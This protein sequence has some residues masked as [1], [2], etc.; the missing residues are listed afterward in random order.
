[1]KHSVIFIVF[2]ALL[3][4]SCNLTTLLPAATEEPTG[5][6]LSTTKLSPSPT[7]LTPPTAEPAAGLVADPY[8]QPLQGLVASPYWPA[9]GLPAGQMIKWQRYA[10]GEAQPPANELVELQ[11]FLDQWAK[12]NGWLA[13][14]RIPSHE[15]LAFRVR[16]LKRAQ[17]GRRL[18]LYGLDE[19]STQ[20]EGSERI[21]LPPPGDLA[22]PKALI[23]APRIEGLRQQISATGDMVEY[24]DNQGQPLL[25]VDAFRMWNNTFLEYVEPRYGGSN[26]VATL[27]PRFR[28]FIPGIEA[29]FFL[30]EKNL[31]LKQIIFLEKTLELYNAPALEPL[32]PHFFAEKKIYVVVPAITEVA[33]ASGLTSAGVAV[34]DR[35]DLFHYKDDLASTIAHEAAHVMQVK[36][37]ANRCAYE[38]GDGTI[39]NGFKDWTADHLVSA[40]EAGQVGAAHVSL[41]IYVKLKSGKSSIDETEDAITSKGKDYWD[42]CTPS[43]DRLAHVEIINTL[44]KP[45]KVVLRGPTPQTVTVNPGASLTIDIAPG[46]YQYEL[47]V[48]GYT[49]LTGKRSFS[50]GPD[51]WRILRS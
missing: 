3:L 30:L 49:T 21:Y 38:I 36:S 43:G 24:L 13:S 8:R 37:K 32:K 17:S 26:M 34:L 6:V 14:A 2:L 7:H 25:K 40:I 46:D 15:K 50:T 10:S 12:W 20:K 19:L 4:L 28:F 44:D 33:N 41:W 48:T 23:L 9:I 16:Q 45:L 35:G 1:M 31:S 29:G 22:K 5:S 27:F 39:P 42:Y 51:T 47:I 18:V 11:N